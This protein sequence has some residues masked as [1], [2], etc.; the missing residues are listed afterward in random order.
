M[1]L[2]LESLFAIAAYA[3]LCLS[4]FPLPEKIFFGT[5]LLLLA[6]LVDFRNLQADTHFEMVY[7]S[8]TNGLQALERSGGN[9][10]SYRVM[11]AIR[12]EENKVAAHTSAH[13]FNGAVFA[14]L[15]YALWVAA[16]WALGSYVLP[17]YLTRL[18]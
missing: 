2:F 13:Q 7:R 6:A 9:P 10:E 4:A 15:K 1:L 16:G 17:H 18:H 12:A 14:L 3:G 8:V 11:D 5:G